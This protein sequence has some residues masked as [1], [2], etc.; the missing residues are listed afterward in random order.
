MRASS[1]RRQFCASLLAAACGLAPA[2][3]AAAA[4]TDLAERSAPLTAL[5]ASLEAPGA[6][7]G[8]RL[9][10]GATRVL[11]IGQRAHGEAAPLPRELPLPVGSV[12]KIV[13]GAA[14]L[15]VCR[16]LGVPL[17]TPVKAL[18]PRVPLPSAPADLTLR[19]LGTHSSQLPEPIAHPDFQAAVLR[20]PAR[21]WPAEAILAYAAG[22]PRA[23]SNANTVLLGLLLERLRD[24]PVATVLRQTVLDPLGLAATTTPAQ[25]GW[26]AAGVRALRHARPGRPLSYGEVPTDVTDLEPG[27][28]GIAG[29]WSSTV[30]DLLA[31]LHGLQVHRSLGDA[32]PADLSQWTSAQSSM[33]FHWMRHGRLQ[34]HSGD[35]PGFSAAAWWDSRSGDSWAVIV[36]LSNTRDGRNPASELVWALTA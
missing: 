36:N 18:L 26:R 5:L 34:G 21:R 14:T 30:D 28:A 2:R 19:A 35:V 24:Q 8:H 29:D 7:I 1:P 33:G 20:E 6:I 4:S 16:E 11:R 13:V 27:W 9:A 25:G 15:I 22:R 12:G 31:L 32:L 23:Y 10:A 17:D 3:R